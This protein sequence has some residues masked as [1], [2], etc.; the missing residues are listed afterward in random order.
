MRTDLT[1]VI[2]SPGSHAQLEEARGQLAPFVR[3]ALVGLNYAYYEPPGAQLLHHNPLFVRSHDFSG[4]T[5]AGVER[6]WQAPQLFGEGLAAGG[7]A[8]L[9]GSLAGFP[10]V[11]SVNEQEFILPAEV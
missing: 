11:P 2:K 9:F 1:K 8:Y 7:G 3:D 5:V 10:Y 6:V 4:D